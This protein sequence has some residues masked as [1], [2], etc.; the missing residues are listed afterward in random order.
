[1]ET[2]QFGSNSS[3][4]EVEEV[5]EKSKKV[6]DLR[7]GDSNKNQPLKNGKSFASDHNSNKPTG[8]PASGPVRTQRRGSVLMG[9]VTGRII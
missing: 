2:S 6:K 4:D 8:N 5:D 9:A 3:V 7:T 1:M